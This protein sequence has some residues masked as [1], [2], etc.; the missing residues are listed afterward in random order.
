MA[1]IVDLDILFPENDIIRFK[2]KSGKTYEVGVFIPPAVG[3]TIIDNIDL[4]QQ[5]FPNGVSSRPR[6]SKELLNF[7]L[8]II[9]DICHEQYPEITEEWLKKNVSFPRLAY[10]LY[11][12]AVPIYE[13]L[14]S[15]GLA[16]AVRP[17]KK[18]ETEG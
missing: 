15:S 17:A 4:I 5:A 12:L 9:A 16:E 1:N 11:K 18:P 14:T 3:F 8:L 13:F 6:V 10:I 7:A 2:D